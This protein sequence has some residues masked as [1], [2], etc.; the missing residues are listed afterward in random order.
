MFGIMYHLSFIT[1]YIGLVLC[2][3]WILYVKYLILFSI[4]LAIFSIYVFFIKSKNQYINQYK[5]IVFEC[6]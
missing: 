2:L 4:P 5:L 3:T 1:F 6:M